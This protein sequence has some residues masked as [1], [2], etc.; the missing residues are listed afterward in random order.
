M[1]FVLSFF[2]KLR[3]GNPWKYKAPLLI[4]WT[5][6]MIF[7]TGIEPKEALIAILMAYSTLFGIAALGYFINDWADIKT[8]KL[9]GKPNKLGE[10]NIQL[11][12][13]ILLILLGFAFVPWIWFPKNQYTYI[14]LGSEIIL[15][16]LYSL[17]PFRLKEKGI[18]GV[19]TDT[20]YAYILPTLLASLTFYLIGLEDYPHM[21]YFLLAVSAWLLVVGIRGILLHQIKD[22]QND[23]NASVKTFVTK[24]GIEFAE[25]ILG[26]LLPLELILLTG[27]FVFVFKE[28]YL[29]FP[30]FILYCIFQ[31]ALQAKSKEKITTKDFQKF[32]NRY[33]DGFYLDYFPVWILIQ[34]CIYDYY[35]LPLLLLHMIF[36]RNFIKN[37]FS[38]FIPQ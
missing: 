34:L 25:K 35:Y 37:I 17:P 33:Y 24:R 11:K 20:L 27:F 7:L 2:T 4:C 21:F 12:L 22:Y 1:G 3:F 18:L 14:L 32:T 8:D 30:G 36:F 31:F 23:L 6:M 26:F 15:F 9:A 19:L 38:K 28:F 10:L 13:L 5:Y 29:L 16:L